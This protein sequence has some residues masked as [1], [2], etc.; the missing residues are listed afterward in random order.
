[1]HPRARSNIPETKIALMPL[2]HSSVLSQEVAASPQ[3]G[4]TDAEGFFKCLGQLARAVT[5]KTATGC[6]MWDAAV[7]GAFY[8]VCLFPQTDS[9]TVS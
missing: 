7:V 9:M 2:F 3:Q 8:L 5:V 4:H 6:L 1:M